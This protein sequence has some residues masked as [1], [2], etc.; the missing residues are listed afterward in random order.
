LFNQFIFLVYELYNYGAH[1]KVRVWI[2]NNLADEEDKLKG[3]E[4]NVGSIVNFF[5]TVLGYSKETGSV[6]ITDKCLSVSGMQSRMQEIFPNIWD[7]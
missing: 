3:A 5:R 4:R 2:I 6:I 7:G 1:D